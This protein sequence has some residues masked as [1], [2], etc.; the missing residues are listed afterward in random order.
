MILHNLIRRDEYKRFASIANKYQQPAKRTN[1]RG[2]SALK[3]N[4]LGCSCIFSAGDLPNLDKGSRQLKKTASRE[5]FLRHGL[6]G[7]VT[8][9]LTERVCKFDTQPKPI[10]EAEPWRLC[11]LFLLSIGPPPKPAAPLTCQDPISRL[12]PR[13]PCARLPLLMSS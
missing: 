8:K 11:L 3:E 13:M 4:L 2:L 5:D 7:L 1:F 6:V 10:V 12:F 9:S